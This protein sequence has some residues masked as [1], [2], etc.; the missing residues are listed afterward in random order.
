MDVVQLSNSFL[1]NICIFLNLDQM[2]IFIVHRLGIHE[3]K[4]KLKKKFNI[5]F[6]GT[7]I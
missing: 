2:M 6:L 3:K 7:Y 1:L 5:N 4:S